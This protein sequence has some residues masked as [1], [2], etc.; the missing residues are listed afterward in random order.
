MGRPP[1][2]IADKPLHPLRQW[3]EAQGLTQAQLA[4]QTDLTQGMISHIERYDRIALGDALARLL[5]R[6]DLPAE[7]LVLP[8]RF[9]A[10][11][12][13]YFTHLSE[14]VNSDKL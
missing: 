5:D 7:A 14:I 1:K 6:T 8:E 9:L 10:H 11:H 13:D 12:P 2:V 4:E 3:R